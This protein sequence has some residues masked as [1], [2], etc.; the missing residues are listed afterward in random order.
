MA[1]ALDIINKVLIGLRQ[2]RL[3]VSTTEVSSKY[4]LLIHQYVNEAKEE[5]EEAWQWHALRQTITVTGSAGVYEYTL[6]SVGDADVDTNERSR[7]LYQREGG[8]EYAGRG[9]GDQPQVWDTTDQAER[10]LT[11]R[12]WEFVERLHITDDDEQNDPCYFALRNNGS[13]LELMVWPTPA[14]ARTFVLRVYVPEPEIA[15]DALGT[16]I[17][18]PQR[19]VYMKALLKAN[20]ERGEELAAP[21]G[22][23][24]ESYIDALAV[25]IQREMTHADTTSHAI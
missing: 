12:S 3:A 2:D 17:T 16:T 19:P 13:N 6:T 10:R 18:V 24:E 15:S 11:E 23:S 20:A 21:N 5:V 1:T 14:D 8:G 4:G 7:L 25:A 22:I 9:W